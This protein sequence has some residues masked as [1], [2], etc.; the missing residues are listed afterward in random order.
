MTNV[1]WNNSSRADYYSKAYAK[2]LASIKSYV[3]QHLLGG[4]KF[5]TWEEI[6][7]LLKL[8]WHEDSVRFLLRADFHPS[9]NYYIGAGY[10]QIACHTD[11]SC[12]ADRF[13]NIG[14]EASPP[15][16]LRGYEKF[17]RVEQF[18]RYLEVNGQVYQGHAV[19]A[20]P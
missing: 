8:K 20:S 2:E 6:E 10:V 1:S 18:V 17:Y 12:V 5:M 16:S 19:E 13:F 14:Y 3:S 4:L 9:L 11:D 7:F 15:E